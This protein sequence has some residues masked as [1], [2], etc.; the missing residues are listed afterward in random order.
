MSKDCIVWGGIRS[1]LP[2]TH[3]KKIIRLWNSMRMQVTR[4]TT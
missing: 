4:R 3:F 1:T 2:I